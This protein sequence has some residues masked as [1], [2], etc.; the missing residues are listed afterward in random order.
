MGVNRFGQGLTA[1]EASAYGDIN[2]E[3]WK[4]YPVTVRVLHL[5]LFATIYCDIIV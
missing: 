3:M 1:A 5:F 4:I 2:R